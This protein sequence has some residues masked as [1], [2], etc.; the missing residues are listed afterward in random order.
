M[1]VSVIWKHEG[2]T[3]DNL[4]RVNFIYGGNG[5][6]KT[7]FS[8][9]LAC[10]DRKTL[11]P[12]REITWTTQKPVQT[13]VYNKDFRRLRNVRRRCILLPRV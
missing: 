11:Y 5:C 1:S 6:G 13:L 3:F 10:D 2:V 12:N 7:T 9:V 4:Q 8:R